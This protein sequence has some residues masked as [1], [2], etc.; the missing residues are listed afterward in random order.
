VV[1]V[2]V[3]IATMISALRGEAEQQD[4]LGRGD[5]G[6]DSTRRLAPGSLVR[7][8]LNATQPPP[9]NAIAFIEALDLT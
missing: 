9:A 8:S 2:V 4:A 6:M 3:V 1:V 7:V 5:G